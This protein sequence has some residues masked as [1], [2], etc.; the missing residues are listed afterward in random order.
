MNAAVALALARETIRTGIPVSG[1]ILALSG[2]TERLE[3]KRSTG[4]RSEATKTIC[5]IHLN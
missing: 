2:E 4:Q 5:G 1:Q 3:F